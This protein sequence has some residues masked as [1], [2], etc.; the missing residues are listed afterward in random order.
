VSATKGS[1]AR[2][3]RIEKLIEQG[4]LRNQKAHARFE[5]RQTRF[6]SNL[7]R[8]EGNMKRWAALGVKRLAP[9][10]D[11]RRNS[12]RR[13]ASWGPRNWSPKKICKI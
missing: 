10:E 13:S 2:L 5:K 11:G 8:L 12:T 9:K 3:D 1:N 6:E 4:E 7:T